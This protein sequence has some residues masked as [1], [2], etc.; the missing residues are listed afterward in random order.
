MSRHCRRAAGYLFALAFLALAFRAPAAAQPPSA[1]AL[2][3]PVHLLQSRTW[4][5]YK[6]ISHDVVSY[7]DEASYYFIK[8]FDTL[9]LHDTVV[10]SCSF[11]NVSRMTSPVTG[12]LQVYY[13]S[14]SPQL[15]FFFDSDPDRRIRVRQLSEA[16][17]EEC[18]L[19]VDERVLKIEHIR[20]DGTP[21]TELFTATQAPEDIAGAIARSRQNK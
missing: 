13:N 9:R 2:S 7:P 21:Y 10:M 12:Q 17:V 14:C 6:V 15:I 20:G 5:L 1:A 19:T 11:S 3:R 8:G 16:G 18:R 4:K